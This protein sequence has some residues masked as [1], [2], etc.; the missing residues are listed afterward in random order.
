MISSIHLMIPSFRLFGLLGLGCMQLLGTVD[1]G[2]SFAAFLR[3]TFMRVFLIADLTNN[4]GLFV[5][6]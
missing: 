4:I 6:N 5:V 2:F 1:M 3:T